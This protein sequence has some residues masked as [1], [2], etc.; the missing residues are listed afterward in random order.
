M[1]ANT[2]SIWL[3]VNADLIEPSDASALRYVVT[4]DAYAVVLGRNGAMEIL[5]ANGT[6]GNAVSWGTDATDANTPR[7]YTDM[8][9][10]AGN[11]SLMLLWQI[12]IGENGYSVRIYASEEVRRLQDAGFVVTTN[13]VWD[14]TAN[15][16]QKDNN[17]FG[18]VLFGITGNGMF[19][20]HKQPG[21]V[22]AWDNEFQTGG[23]SENAF[24]WDRTLLG[25]SWIDGSDRASVEINNPWIL[26]NVAGSPE[27]SN[28][29]ASTNLSSGNYLTAKNLIKAWGQID[30]NSGT[31]LTPGLTGTTSDGFQVG[32]YVLSDANLS[33]TVTFDNGFQDEGA[34]NVGQFGYCVLVAT[35]GNQ[36]TCTV[37]RIG[38]TSFKIRSYDVIAG[39]LENF[40]SGNHNLFWAVLG[41]HVD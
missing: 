10:L 13:A 8:P 11:D 3:T 14:N 31:I 27:G 38:G 18:A 41:N 17:S 25:T 22:A 4:G 33:I 40:S 20:G 29:T 7:I 15:T 24:G 37:E 1:D 26:L 39:A 36:N 23:G 32:S 21:A 34:A 5:F 2:G 6:A 30:I 28:V 19:V 12:P 35:E 16:W 9:N